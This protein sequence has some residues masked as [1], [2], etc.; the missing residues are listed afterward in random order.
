[1]ASKYISLDPRLYHYILTSSLRE[2]PTL[3]KPHAIEAS[4]Y[5]DDNEY[6]KLCPVRQQLNAQRSDDSTT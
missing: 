3:V 4:V 6:Y 2:P 1:M 5:S